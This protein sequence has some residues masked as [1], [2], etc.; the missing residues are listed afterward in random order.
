MWCVAWGLGVVLPFH[1]GLL[2]LAAEA[3]DPC[4]DAQRQPRYCLPELM[5]LAAGHP[6]VASATCGHS[7]QRLCAAQGP[8]GPR[9]CLLCNQ[10]SPATAHPAAYLTDPAGEATC[11]HSGPVPNATLTLALGGRFEVLYVAIRF[12]T[13]RPHSMA[14]YKSMDYGRSWIPFQFFS[15]RCRSTYGQPPALAVLKGMEHEATCT[16]GQ[17]SP[18]PPTRGLVAFMPLAGRPSASAFEYSPVLQDWVMATDLRMTLDRRH[19]ARELGV[20]GREASYGVSELQVGGRCQCN[21]HAS[22]CHVPSRDG[23]PQCQC[24]HDTTGPECET[25]RAFYRDRPWQR[26]TPSDA[27]EC[28]TCQC[29]QHSHRCRFSMELYE[30]SGRKSGGVCLHCR[31]HT[32]GRHCHYCQ[33]GFW[34]DPRRPLTS[35]KACK[36]CQCHPI[37]AVSNFC[38][39]TTGQC[40]CKVGVAGLTCNRCAQGF[41]QSRSALMPCVRTECRSHCT[42][43]HG[44]IRMNLR[45]YCKKDYV[46]HAQI[47]AAEES[48]EWQKFTALVL[49]VYLQRSV[50]IRRGEHP[51]WVPQQD[52]ACDCLRLQ[53]DKAYL[54]IGNDAESP[55]P[56]RLVL[57][58]NSLALPWRDA[59]AHKLRSFQQQNRRGQCRVP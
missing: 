32:T 12:C 1:L 23:A 35:H 40:Q 47:T 19:R 29:H 3:P 7:P 41:Q 10:A 42:P 30:L 14:I 18:N 59:W 56:A 31:H 22:H 55:D 11:W 34:R 45:N 27:H 21:G 57:D 50:P 8:P 28:V 39:Q 9:L 17:T 52:L 16:D 25:C 36:A 5:D 51:L 15:R 33:P 43:S 54:V 20:R 38:N 46:L 53:V 48:G 49:A 24:Q 6:V 2:S 44:R 4:Y 58:R 13:P 26:A 37:G